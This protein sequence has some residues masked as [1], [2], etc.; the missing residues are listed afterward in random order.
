MHVRA[1]LCQLCVQ[2]AVAAA[3]DA[4]SDTWVQLSGHQALSQV[5]KHPAHHDVLV[6]AATA[7]QGANGVGLNPIAEED[8]VQSGAAGKRSTAAAQ[9]QARPWKG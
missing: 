7:A 1:A 4:A 5:R 2:V 6:A 3:D 9:E 8:E